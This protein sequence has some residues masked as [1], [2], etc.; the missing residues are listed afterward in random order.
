MYD[1]H[2]TVF[3]TASW[4]FEQSLASLESMCRHIY[5]ARN[6]HFWAHNVGPTFTAFSFKKMVNKGVGSENRLPEVA[7]V[8]E[9][10]S[11]EDEVEVVRKKVKLD[12]NNFLSPLQPKHA[13]LVDCC[14]LWRFMILQLNLALL[15]F[16]NEEASDQP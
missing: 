2:L 10:H 11:D 4:L 15:S 1:W 12:C 14:N 7:E 9:D 16:T 8:V 5:C 3:W 6:I 13:V